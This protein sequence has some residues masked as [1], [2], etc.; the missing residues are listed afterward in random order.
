[1]YQ[2]NIFF[3]ISQSH[4][5]TVT[6]RNTTKLVRVSVTCEIF[7]VDGKAYLSWLDRWSF[8]LCLWV[9]CSLRW[10]IVI[11]SHSYSS[12]ASRSDAVFSTYRRSPA[13]PQLAMPP[14]VAKHSSNNKCFSEFMATAA[15]PD[16]PLMPDLLDVLSNIR[17]LPS[18][19]TLLKLAFTYYTEFSV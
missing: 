14:T 19:L 17:D 12:T 13:S 7:G 10:F 6:A 18:P 8:S 3:Q 16:T 15:P 2:R 11:S 4:R 1:M 5:I 9:I